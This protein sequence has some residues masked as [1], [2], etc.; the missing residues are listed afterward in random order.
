VKILFIFAC[1]K[2]QVMLYELVVIQVVFFCI[3]N[4]R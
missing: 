4:L 1:G 3:D 2:P